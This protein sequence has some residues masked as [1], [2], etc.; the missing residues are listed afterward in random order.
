[1]RS[2]VLHLLATFCGLSAIFLTSLICSKCATG[3]KWFVLTFIPLIVGF[4]ISYV[5]GRLAVEEKQRVRAYSIITTVNAII[6]IVL[7]IAAIFRLGAD[8]RILLVALT[9]TMFQGM[10]ITYMAGRA[11]IQSTTF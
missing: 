10:Y 2:K 8:S 5:W 9:A 3:E 1:M 11:S 4:V 7:D 6:F